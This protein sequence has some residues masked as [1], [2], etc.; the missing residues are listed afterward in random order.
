MTDARL[1][2]HLVASPLAGALVATGL[3]MT[4]LEPL[5]PW[6]GW[7]LDGAAALCGAVGLLGGG[8]AGFRLAPGES[9]TTQSVRSRGFRVATF[10]VS[11]VTLWTAFLLAGIPAMNWPVLLAAL[12]GGTTA[13]WMWSN[14]T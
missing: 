4:F 7:A 8:I 5:L 1:L 13:A 2:W 9:S 10:A 6:P 11:T 14:R 12:M 3:Y